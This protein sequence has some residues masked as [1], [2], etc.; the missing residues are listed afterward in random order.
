MNLGPGPGL[1]K[2]TGLGRGTELG[3]GV[4]FGIGAGLGQNGC[5][6]CEHF[7]FGVCGLFTPHHRR[8]YNPYCAVGRRGSALFVYYCVYYMLV[9]VYVIEFPMKIQ[10]ILRF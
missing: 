7:P 6:H 4:G 2:G 1:G 5:F 9:D 8:V 10:K 3:K